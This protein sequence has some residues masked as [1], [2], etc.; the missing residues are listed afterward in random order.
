M[1][2]FCVS[3]NDNK[4]TISSVDNENSH[5]KN[6]ERTFNVQTRANDPMR[7]DT[8]P[9]VNLWIRCSSDDVLAITPKVGRLNLL[10]QAMT[11]PDRSVL[12]G[13]SAH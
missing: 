7:K 12:A 2:Y 6:C 3:F 5:K 13:C 4:G 11:I 9:P 1:S 8:A 10:A